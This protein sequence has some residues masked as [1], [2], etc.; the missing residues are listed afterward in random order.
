MHGYV[1]GRESAVK[2]EIGSNEVS[3]AQDSDQ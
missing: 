2:V 3:T 1:H